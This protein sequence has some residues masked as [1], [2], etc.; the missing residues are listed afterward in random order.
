MPWGGG[1]RPTFRGAN[2]EIQSYRGREAMLTGP[3]E[4]G[5]TYAVLW[6]LDGLMRST[7]KAHAALV[8]KVAADIG[9]T[10]LVTYKRIIE[11]SRSGA[12]PFGG[13]KPEWFDYPNGARLYVGGMDRPGKVLSGERDFIYINQA[14]ELTLE[15]WETL[16]TRCTGRGAVTSTPMIFG[17]CN[18]GPDGH[19]IQKRETLRLFHSRHE[20]NPSLYDDEGALTEQGERTMQTLDALTGVR[21]SRL[22][23]GLWVSA[24]GMVYED[25]WNAS[26]HLI[27]PNDA[28]YGLENGI[29]S[30]WPRYWA[31]DFGFTNPF[32]WASYAEDPDGRLF[33]YK[34]IYHTQRLVED[35]ARDILKATEGEPLPRAI[36]CDHDA[37]GRATLE[38]YLGMKTQ[39]AYKAVTEGIQAMAA[40]LR[41]AGDSKPRFFYIK[42]ALV[43]RDKSLIEKHLPTSA[44]TE[45]ESYIWDTS[46]SRKKGEEP[47]KKNDHGMDRDRYLIAHVDK[48]GRVSATPYSF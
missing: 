37:E 42:N 48:I 40:R 27:E 33:R 5:K 46:N 24:E 18:P 7:P 8:R 29:P 6:L 36:I 14:E 9:P 31:V 30:T 34:E 11:M 38:K 35:H 26:L 23:H 13:E 12:K 47:V 17:D 4:T 16:T 1:E 22:R 45:I 25:V 20:D 44:E 15:D 43:E 10:V 2:D 19:W 32:T 21:K 41:V 39:P 3:A 28:R